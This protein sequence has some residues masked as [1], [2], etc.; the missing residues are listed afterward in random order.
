MVDQKIM[1]AIKDISKLKTRENPQEIH[2][3]I[4]LAL[5]WQSPSRHTLTSSRATFFMVRFPIVGRMCVSVYVRVGVWTVTLGLQPVLKSE[6]AGSAE[7]GDTAS[8]NAE[9]VAR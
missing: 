7:R 5:I 3:S 1:T 6:R 4:T 9:C 2:P 8:S